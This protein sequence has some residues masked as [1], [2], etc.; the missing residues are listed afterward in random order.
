MQKLDPKA[1]WLFFIQYFFGFGIV[2]FSLCVF[3]IPTLVIQSTFGGDSLG[4][5]L[6]FII[7][8]GFLLAVAAFSYL[9]AVLTYN[10][11]QYELAEEGFKKEQGVI[12]KKYVTIPYDRIQNVDI[13]RGLLSR[14]IGLSDLQVQTAGF[15]MAGQYGAASEGRLPALSKEVAE[16]IRSELVKRAKNKKS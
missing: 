8:C 1:V 4:F 16:E 12:F 2:S 10:N 5:L 3:I 14:I 9:W 15:S 6:P 13:Y 7:C 11:F